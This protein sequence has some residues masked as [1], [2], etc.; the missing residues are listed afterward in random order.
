MQAAVTRL[1]DVT[2]HKTAICPTQVFHLQYFNLRVPQDIA[3]T[4]LLYRT[5]TE[6]LMKHRQLTQHEI[7]QE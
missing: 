3:V 7:N 4:T 5:R 6:K 2:S 1:H